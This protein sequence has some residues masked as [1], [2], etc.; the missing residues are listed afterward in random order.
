MRSLEHVARSTSW[1]RVGFG[2]CF[3]FEERSTREGSSA[4]ADE[5]TSE[6][7]AAVELL[8]TLSHRPSVPAGAGDL[9]DVGNSGERLQQGPDR[10]VDLLVVGL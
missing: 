1:G 5:G 9:E 7:A 8:W 2:W 6:E 10:R 3:G 4:R